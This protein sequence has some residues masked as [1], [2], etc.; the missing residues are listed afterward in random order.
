MKA[1][2]ERNKVLYNLNLF[3]FSPFLLYR[4]YF[5]AKT[6]GDFLRVHFYEKM[7]RTVQGPKVGLKVMSK[8]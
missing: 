7:V 1:F 3:F 4:D 6:V 8:K 5:N 2:L